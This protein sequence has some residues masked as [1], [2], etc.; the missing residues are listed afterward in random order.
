ML[1]RTTRLISAALSP[2]S[3]TLPV[4]WRSSKFDA[5]KTVAS[6]Q[7][8]KDLVNANRNRTPG[9]LR[10]EKSWK[11]WSQMAIESIRY[12]LSITSQSE[13]DHDGFSK[14]FFK[15][16]EAADRGDMPS[17]T[18]AGS[19]SGYALDFF[20]RARLLAD[21]LWKI[22]ENPTIPANWKSNGPFPLRNIFRDKTS[23]CRLVS[24][25]SGPAYDFVA[26]ALL[27]EFSNASHSTTSTVDAI[28]FDYEEGWKD[29]VRDMSVSTAAT[30]MTDGQHSCQWGGTC[31]ITKPL[32]DPI[33]T[34][35][36]AE[37]N[38][39]DIFVCQYCVAENANALRQ[40]KFAFFR[41]ALLQAP[42]GALFILTETTT[43]LWPEFVDLAEE[44]DCN[45]QIGFVRNVGRGKN[46][47]Y[48][49]IRKLHFLTPQP[50]MT[51]DQRILYNEFQS[52]KTMHER[53]LSTGWERQQRKIRGNK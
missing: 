39:F 5:S 42:M 22:E 6:P 31:D 41:D 51:S 35:C 24:I 40:S 1:L 47:P 36:K 14:L 19:R 30:L 7:A 43:R 34:A 28:A 25:G 29:A 2:T 18:C 12:E 49:M 27:A 46:G 9:S 3:T 15:L 4:R 33:N 32:S 23:K 21:L 8:L 13:I 52:L 37:L 16:G 48:L 10:Y 11:T 53:K 44:L 20:C 38:S 50:I 45:L 26:A 17:F